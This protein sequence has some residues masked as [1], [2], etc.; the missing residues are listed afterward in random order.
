MDL[1]TGMTGVESLVD[2]VK[3]PVDGASSSLSVATAAAPILHLTSSSATISNALLTTDAM[4]KDSIDDDA[5]GSDLDVTF[6]PCT[7]SICLAV[8]SMFNQGPMTSR[9]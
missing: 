4:S 8:F 6:S 1:F 7:F 5:L 9:Q 3:Q 2:V